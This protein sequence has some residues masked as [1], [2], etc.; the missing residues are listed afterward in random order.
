MKDIVPQESIIR[1]SIMRTQARIAALEVIRESKIDIKREYEI[2]DQM[3]KL[4]K[5]KYGEFK[6]EN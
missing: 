5:L 1:L 4:Y 6:Y 2:L 3:M